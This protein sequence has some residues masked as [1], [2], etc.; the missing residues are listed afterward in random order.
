M[1]GFNKIKIIK[2]FHY[3]LNK[4]L[5]MYKYI[6]FLILILFA[7]CSENKKQETKPTSTQTTSPY[8]FTTIKKAGLES[9]IKLPA[10]LAAYEEV[11]IFPKVNGYV[12]DVLV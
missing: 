7:S 3:F 12:K 6:A 5:F 8:E 11:S 2:M 4:I 9:N 10:Q 1:V